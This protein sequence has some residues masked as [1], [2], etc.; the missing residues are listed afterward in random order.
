MIFFGGHGTC[1]ARVFSRA[2]FWGGV[3]WADLPRVFS[4]FRSFCGHTEGTS[5]FSAVELVNKRTS[6]ASDTPWAI[7][8][9]HRGR[10]IKN[11]RNTKQ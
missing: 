6:P 8:A 7:A 9:V 2:L 10:D 5:A 3:E 4:N 1:A 11:A